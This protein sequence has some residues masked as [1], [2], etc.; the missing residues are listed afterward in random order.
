MQIMWKKSGTLFLWQDAGTVAGIK[1]RLPMA[2]LLNV[3]WG[4]IFCATCLLQR[5]LTVDTEHVEHHSESCSCVD[6]ERSSVNAH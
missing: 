5:S 3:G 4:L 6:F 2:T 1:F